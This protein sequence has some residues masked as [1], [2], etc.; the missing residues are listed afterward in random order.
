LLATVI[1]PENSAMY[2]FPM[3]RPLILETTFAFGCGII[4]YF[5]VERE[6]ALWATR[7]GRP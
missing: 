1:L 2:F 3:P 6:P 5:A 7:N 4:V